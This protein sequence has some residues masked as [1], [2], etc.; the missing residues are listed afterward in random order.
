MRLATAGALFLSLCS[1]PLRPAAAALQDTSPLVSS[2]VQDG[3]G[4]GAAKSLHQ[5]VACFGMILGITGVF[6]AFATGPLIPIVAW[7]VAG[8]AVQVCGG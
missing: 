6:L 8:V 2:P 3:A 4:R 5:V 7:A 1:L